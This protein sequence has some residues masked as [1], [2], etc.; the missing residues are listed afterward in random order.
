M[1]IVPAESRLEIEAMVLNKDVGF[2]RK[3]QEA[4]ITPPV[5]ELPAVIDEDYLNKTYVGR[6][7]LQALQQLYHDSA[8]WAAAWDQPGSE[9]S[10][11]EQEPEV[12]PA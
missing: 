2:V 7:R 12:Q 4:V 6:E 8:A 3:G 5:L 1:V 10:W 11:E 9:A